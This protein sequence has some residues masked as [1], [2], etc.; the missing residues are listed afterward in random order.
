MK[1]LKLLVFAAVLAGAPIA[2]AAQSV[3]GDWVSPSGD[4]RVRIAPCGPSMCGT[5]VW[6]KEATDPATGALLTDVNNP[7]KALR[8]RTL[9]GMRFLE[10]FRPTAD[11][12]W[13]DGRIYDAETGH[14]YRSKLSVRADGKLRLEGCLGP[15]C[16]SQYWSR[17]G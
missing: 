2:A 4:A 3:A 10:G 8:G 5:I 16:R 12:G 11:G 17:A 15:L 9:V 1:D 13:T 7:D 6:L 14:T